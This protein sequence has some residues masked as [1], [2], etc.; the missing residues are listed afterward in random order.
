MTVYLGLMSGTSMDGIDAAITNVSKNQLLAAKTYPY[1]ESVRRQLQS[2]LDNERHSIA[3]YCHL[4]SVL[5][6]EF[7]SAANALIAANP[8]LARQIK[9]IGSH[10]QTLAHDTLNELPYTLQFGCGHTIAEETGYPVVADFRARDLVLG[11]QG[12]PFAPAYHQHLFAREGSIAVVNIGGICNVT[13]LGKGKV[14]GFDV[15]PGNCLLDA[16]IEQNLNK[17]YDDCGQWARKG[18]VQESLLTQLLADPYFQRPAPKAIGKEYFSLD[19]LATFMKEDYR[20]VDIQATLAQLTVRTLAESINAADKNEETKAIVIC[21]GGAHNTYM[22]EQLAAQFPAK[23][24]TTSAAYGIN[25]D[26]I[27]AMMF[28]WLAEKTMTNTAIDLR[29]ITGSCSPTILG[30]IFPAGIDKRI[31]DAV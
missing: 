29:N 16:W 7:A 30:T 15:G 3:E 26:F 5:G 14:Q 28:A 20:A 19:W 22:L 10:G 24:V 31:C 18:K 12:A 6:K 25:P 11:G 17:T 8:Q 27:E 13:L 23:K 2:F 1:K 4:N 21:G 9:A